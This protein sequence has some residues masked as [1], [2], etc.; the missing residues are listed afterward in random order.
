MKSRRNYYRLLRVQPDASLDVIKLCYR[1]LMQTLQHHPD[2]GGEEWDAQNI[3]M[4]Y[5][6]LRNPKKRGAYDHKLFQKQSVKTVSRGHLG[7]ATKVRSASRLKNGTRRNYYRILQVQPDAEAEIIRAVYKFLKR[8]EKNDHHLLDNAWK[9]LSNE[10]KRRIYDESL[11]NAKSSQKKRQTHNHSQQTQ[12]QHTSSTQSRQDTASRAKHT[13]HEQAEAP[14]KQNSADEKEAES[15]YRGPQCLF[16]KT[17]YIDNNYAQKQDYCFRC[18]SPL[19][20]ISSDYAKLPR[21]SIER[22]KTQIPAAIYSSWP[23]TPQRVSATDLSP[24]GFGFVSKVPLSAGQLVKIDTEQ[25]RAVGEVRYC[26]SLGPFSK[27]GVRF[28]SIKFQQQS[29][30]F[31]YKTA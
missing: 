19:H 20:G 9:T 6:V 11:K 3:N 8:D 23:S 29:G 15:Q 13:R 1:T 14:K 22:K 27:V 17:P 31:F 28:V 5:A 16:C 2:L 24:T 7:S 26:K 25:F 4:A 30:T 12:Q 21:R 18:G 10:N